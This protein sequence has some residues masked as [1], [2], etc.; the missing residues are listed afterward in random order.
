MS[1]ILHSGVLV[2][3][4]VFAGGFKVGGGSRTLSWVGV[5]VL[6]RDCI[7]CIRLSIVHTSRRAGQR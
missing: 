5:G 4:V 6:W 7:R 2:Y 3:M 1:S